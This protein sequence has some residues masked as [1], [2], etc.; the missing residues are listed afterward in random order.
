MID[1]TCRVAIIRLQGTFCFNI[2]M[3]LKLMDFV[4]EIDEQIA[5]TGRACND[6]RIWHISPI[7]W[8]HYMRAIFSYFSIKLTNY[9]KY[10]F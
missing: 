5:H 1:V 6:F 4:F 8:T 10:L 2:D 7:T 3:D 9:A